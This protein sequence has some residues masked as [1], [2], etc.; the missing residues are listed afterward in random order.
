MVPIE[1]MLFSS[2]AKC[3][4]SMATISRLRNLTCA[5]LSV[6]IV[7]SIL[8]TVVFRE[9]NHSRPVGHYGSEGKEDR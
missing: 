9:R 2:I 3:Q 1:S 5:T 6:A 4:G 7:D 8:R